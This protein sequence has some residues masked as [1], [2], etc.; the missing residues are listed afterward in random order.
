MAKNTRGKGSGTF[1]MN[2]Q[3]LN[4]VALDSVHNTCIFSCFERWLKGFSTLDTQFQNGKA[5]HE[6]GLFE[7]TLEFAH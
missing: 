1:K 5:L 4:D 7:I 2:F 3:I 6:V